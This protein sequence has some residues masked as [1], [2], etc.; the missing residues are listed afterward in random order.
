MAASVIRRN[1]K[2]KKKMK[3]QESKERKF[4]KCLSLEY[5]SF[6]MSDCYDLYESF[7]EKF[8]R[9]CNNIQLTGFRLFLPNIE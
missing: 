9:K 5:F 1:T 7:Y 2:N 8:S 6:A 3:T 4:R